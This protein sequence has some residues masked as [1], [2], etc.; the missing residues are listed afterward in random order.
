MQHT[1]FASKKDAVRVGSV[2]LLVGIVSLLLPLAVNAQS[3]PLAAGTAQKVRGNSSVWYITSSCTRRPIKNRTVFF[4]YFTSWNDVRETNASK[5]SSVPV[6]SLG[7]LPY[8][9]RKSFQNGSLIKTVD[10]PSVYLVFD[11]KRHPID[12]EEMF[13]KAGYNFRQVID[14]SSGARDTFGLGNRIKQVID[15]PNV[16][17]KYRNSPKVYVFEGK[18]GESGRTLKHI[19]SMSE[20]R[21]YYDPLR[22]VEIDSKY[23]F[24]AQAEP[25]KIDTKKEAKKPSPAEA[26]P[27]QDTGRQ[28]A[29]QTNTAQPAQPTQPTVNSSAVVP[30]IR[31]VGYSNVNPT[32][33]GQAP[34]SVHVHAM[35]S[36]LAAGNAIT[37]RYS[38]DFGDSSSGSEYNTL[39]GFGGAHIY[40]QPGTYTIALRVTNEN[41]QTNTQQITVNV[42]SP[43]RQRIYVSSV[44]DD[45]NSGASESTA[46]RSIARVQQL[47][48]SNKEVLFRRGDSF[49][50]DNAQ[51]SI[52]G[53]SNVRI[54][55]YG[56]GN[57][58]VLSG[59]RLSPNNWRTFISIMSGSRHIVIE[60][61]SFQ[62]NQL[63]PPEDRG[64]WTAISSEGT[65]TR[66]L[67]IRDNT[68]SNLTYNISAIGGG[69]GVAPTG[70]LV[71]NNTSD[72]VSHYHFWG[73]GSDHTV[74]GNT[75]GNSLNGHVTRF[76]ADR[77]FIQYNDFDSPGYT[78]PNDCLALTGQQQC[79]GNQVISAAESQ[80]SYIANNTLRNI[81]RVGY[82]DPDSVSSWL[83]VENNRFVRTHE[84]YIPSIRV[85]RGSQYIDIRNNTFENDQ[86]PVRI[87]DDGVSTLP[88]N[89]RIIDN[90]FVNAPAST[91]FAQDAIGLPASANLTIRN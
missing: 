79:Q 21:A 17:I 9:P 67:T 62:I 5:L 24:R 81:M 15:L 78:N 52:D 7:F 26:A 23:S 69:S 28:N 43:A 38:W 72:V 60:D 19:Q 48:G 76:Y 6:D 55:A 73:Q 29:N 44:G 1:Q 34:L 74:L 45:A 41:Q 42:T 13:Y 11:G 8:G 40:D 65:G 33:T 16:A 91:Q 31:A 71:L 50:F 89:L 25:A 57:A 30:R 36:Q 39:D 32:I 4:S 84:T 83:V 35:E 10:D 66:N 53:L 75:V 61:L 64:S 3:C 20:L 70:I 22:V 68:F 82:H 77:I 2:S 59:V 46:V 86:L 18:V 27:T 14:V 12:S 56:S 47:L 90:R 85:F 54:G 51:L 88:G 49:P 80:Y 37:A 87:D 63:P 58:P